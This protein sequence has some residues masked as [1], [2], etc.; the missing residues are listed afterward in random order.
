MVDFPDPMVPKKNL[1]DDIGCIVG[2]D[3]YHQPTNHDD[4]THP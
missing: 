4:R 2:A 3:A 1:S